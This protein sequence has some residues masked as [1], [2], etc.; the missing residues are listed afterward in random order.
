MVQ[1][2]RCTSLNTLSV[3]PSRA[4]PHPAWTQKEEKA[5]D[6]RVA[7]ANYRIKQAGQMYERK[8]KK[9][10]ED[11]AEEHNR[12][13]SLLSSLGPEITQEKQSASSTVRFSVRAR[14]ANCY[15]LP[16]NHAV[17]V[18]Q[19]HSDTLFSVAAC[20]ARVAD[21][22]WLRACEGVR[23]MSPC[24]GAV[25]EWRALCEGERRRTS[26]SVWHRSHSGPRRM[27]WAR[28]P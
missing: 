21:A 16:S 2:T 28:A 10:P 11:A 26:Q 17:A 24:A 8:V 15:P 20:L 6:E 22:E 23:R 13:I 1:E 5:H 12:Y 9:N 3:A 7:N 27:E 4:C 19:R 14:L 25:G 18:T